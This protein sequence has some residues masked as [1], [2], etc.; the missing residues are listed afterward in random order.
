MI[1]LGKKLPNFKHIALVA[2]YILILVGGIVSN[3]EDLMIVLGANAL[4]SLGLIIGG[5]IFGDFTAIAIGIFGIAVF[6][7]YI[8]SE[9]IAESYLCSY[10]LYHA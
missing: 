9:I 1:F 7:I 5:L 10:N 6:L 8:A 2:I 4:Y 3:I